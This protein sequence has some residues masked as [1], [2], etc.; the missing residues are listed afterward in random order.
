MLSAC[1][2]KTKLKPCTVMKEAGEYCLYSACETLIFACL[3]SN[4]IL[5][6]AH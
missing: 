4:N 6:L 1:R 2:G 5:S 3:V